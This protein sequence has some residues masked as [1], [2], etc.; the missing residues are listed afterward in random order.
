M[1]RLQCS[2]RELHG[3]HDETSIDHSKVSPGFAHP[4]AHICCVRHRL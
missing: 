3:V 4:R 1:K 2:G